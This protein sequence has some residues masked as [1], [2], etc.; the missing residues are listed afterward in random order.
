L[1]EPQESLVGIPVNEKRQRAR[2]FPMKTT[3]PGDDVYT[4]DFRRQAVFW[5]REIGVTNAA[6]QLS[7]S[8]ETLK[9]WEKE[10]ASGKSLFFRRF[11][12]RHFPFGLKIG[13]TGVLI[14]ISGVLSAAIAETLIRTTG[15]LFAAKALTVVAYSLV[16]SGAL[17]AA[18]GVLMIWGEM[19]MMVAK[20]IWPG[21]SRKWPKFPIMITFHKTGEVKKI[22]RASELVKEFAY[23]DTDNSEEVTAVDSKNREVR[24]FIS[25]FKVHTCELISGITLG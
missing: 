19:F 22:K 1:L 13:F 12:R 5:V 23:L 25:A 9:K 15:I 16:L 4:D 11:F 2:R 17:M 7:I 6:Q 24:L 18:V 14:G 3:H 21:I 20:K 8:E 10:I